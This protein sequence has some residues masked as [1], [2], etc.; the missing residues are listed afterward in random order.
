MLPKVITSG[1]GEKARDILVRFPRQKLEVIHTTSSIVELILI[2]EIMSK[3]QNPILA[4]Q[5]MVLI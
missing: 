3:L 5:N 4:C 2:V 1:L